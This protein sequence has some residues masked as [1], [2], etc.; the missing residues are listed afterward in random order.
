MPRS[1]KVKKRKIEAD[2]IYGSVLVQKFINKIMT[3]GKAAIAEKILYTALKD[4]ASKQ[5]KDPL[6]VFEGAIKNVT[7]LMEVKSRRVGGSTYQIPVEVAKDRGISLAMKWLRDN[8][9]ERPGKSMQEKLAVEL[10]DAYN[11]AGGAI[12]KR[13][14]AHKMAEANKAFSHFRW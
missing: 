3:C 7:P 10:F 5:K 9:R 1:G 2:P 14:D 12:K 11:N 8:A 6:E 13:E 4:I